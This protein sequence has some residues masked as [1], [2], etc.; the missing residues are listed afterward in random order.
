MMP[1]MVMTSSNRDMV[2]KLSMGG[3]KRIRGLHAG[4]VCTACGVERVVLCV[5]VAVLRV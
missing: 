3:M 2:L 4:F 1:M 5:V